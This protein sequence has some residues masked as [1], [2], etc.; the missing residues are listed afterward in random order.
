MTSIRGFLVTLLLAIIILTI[1]LSVVQGYQASSTEIQQQMDSR[2]VDIA[3]LLSNQHINNNAPSYAMHAEEHILFQVFNHKEDLLHYSTTATEQRLV[4]LKQ[5]FS[6][7]NFNGNRWRAFAFFNSQ[8]DLWVVVAERLD[9]RFDLAEKIILKSLKPIV[10]G[11]SLAALLIWL[12]IG[13][14]LK[15]L[16][17]LSNALTNKREDDLSPLSIKQPYKEVEQVIQSSNSLLKRLNLSLEREKRF[18]SDVAHELRTPLSVLKIDIFNLTRKLGKDD[19]EVQALNRG[20]DRMERLVQQILTLY[21]TT[22][23]QFM[24]TF[25]TLDLYSLT[26]KVI[27]D[28]YPKFD[29]KS[30]NIELQGESAVIKG[31]QNSLETLLLNLV[32]NANKYT[33]VGGSI[34]VA[35]FDQGDSIVLQVEDSGIGIPE[36][37]YQRVFERFYRVNGDCHSSNEAGCGI[38]LS[39]VKHIVY[40]HKAV[41]SLQ[42]SEYETGLMVRVIFKKIR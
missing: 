3:K 17:S 18:A 10:L 25:V 13:H 40:L 39:I 36:T 2:L 37:Q 42:H 20:V 6:E 32:E 29:K 15:P 27:A 1:F 9:I 30:Q 19:K 24:A 23:D 28:Q 35:V 5:E 33:P 26:Q 21:R 22:P 12:V 34:R 7:I 16:Y 8:K 41:I 31:D 11:I 14:G 4:P 38:G